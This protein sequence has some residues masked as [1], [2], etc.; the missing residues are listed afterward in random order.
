MTPTPTVSIGMPVYNA[1]RYL[2]RALD[3]LLAQDFRDFEL[4][5]S[6]NGSTDDTEA[7]CRVYAGRDAR[8]RFIR[9]RENRG[10]LWNFAHVL[11]QAQG[12]FFLWA[13]HDDVYAP[14]FISKCLARLR[15]CPSAI[16]CCSEIVFLDEAGRVKPGWTYVNLDTL[17]MSSVDR[18]LELFR[19]VGWFATYSLFRKETLRKALPFPEAYGSD[20]ISLLDLLLLG[21]ITKVPE[22]LFMLMVADQGKSAQQYSE[23]M[24]GTPTSEA[25]A[26]PYTGL[27]RDL[28]VRA[29]R[30]P[31]TSIE[32]ER[33]R[34]E[35]IRILSSE[36]QDWR[37]RI[38][39]ELGPEGREAQ[40]EGEFAR[41]LGK[42]MAEA[43]GDPAPEE[44]SGGGS[45]I[46]PRALVFFPHNPWPAR[47]GAHSRCLTM[48]KA[49]RGLGY[50][51]TLCGSSQFTD[52]P[53]GLE[54]RSHLEQEFE[55]EVHVHEPDAADLA[56]SQSRE[57]ASGTLGLERFCPPGLVRLF[58]ELQSKL[59]AE[60]VLVNY[61]FWGALAEGAPF[62]RAVTVIDSH[63][64]LAP[65]SR[66]NQA[67]K[68]W[69]PGGPLAPSDPSV[70]WL[71]DDCGGSLQCRIEVQDEEEFRIYDRFDLT[72]AISEAEAGILESHCKRTRVA[73]VRMC[74]EE[75][76]TANRYGGRPVFL[77]SDNLSNQQGYLYFVSRVLPLIREQIPGFEIGVAGALCRRIQPTPG[78]VPLGYVEDLA[79]LYSDA[80]FAICPLLGGTGQQ[81]K[82]T[83]AMAYGV[84]VVVHQAVAGSS[85]VVSEVNGFIAGTPETFAA[86]CI[87]LT[88]DDELRRRLGAEA[89][90]AMQQRGSIAFL[91][92]Q[93]N[94]ALEAARTAF[95]NRPQPR[96]TLYVRTD[97]IGDAILSNS[98]LPH[99]RAQWPEEHITV[100]CQERVAE[101]YRACP[102]VD[103]VLSFDRS[104]ALADEAYR[105]ALSTRIQNVGADRT[106]CPVFS[107]EVLTDLLVGVSQAPVRIGMVGDLSNQSADEMA[108]TDAIY[109]HLIPSRE[110]ATSELDRHQDFLSGLGIEADGLVPTVWTTDGD[111]RFAEAHFQRE[112][113]TGSRVLA[114]FPG[115]QYDARV[116]GGYR[117]ILEQLAGEGWRLL[118][119]GSQSEAGLCAGMLRGLNGSAN[120]CGQLSLGQV[121]A[122]LRRC[123]LGLGAESGLAHL[124]CAVGLPNAI[125]LGG[126]HF[127][128]FCPSSPKTVAAVLPLDCYFCNWQ[129]RYSRPHCVKDLAAGVVARAVELAQQPSDRPRLVAQ[130]GSFT[131]RDDHPA[132]IDLA[133]F[134]NLEDVGYCTV[135]VEHSFR[136]SEDAT[137]CGS[138]DPRPLRTTV[139]CAVW[140]QDP[141]RLDLLRGH[142]ACLD[143]L[144]DAVDRIYVFDGG[145]RAPE[146][147]KGK[148]V[149]SREPLTIYEAWNLALP[150]VRTPYVMNL[151]LDDRLCSDGVARLEAALDQGADLACGDWRI[152][153]TRTETDAFEPSFQANE[154]PVFRSWP[155]PTGEAARLGSSGE[156]WTL[157]PACLW[158]TALHKEFPRFP[159]KFA[160]GVLIRTIGDGVW[161]RL[162]DQFGKRI[163]RLPWVIGHY[164]SNPGEQ[165]EFRN[166]PAIEEEKLTRTGIEF[167]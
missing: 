115:A 113:L 3:A 65:N 78:V 138:P 57:P 111:E 44:A 150:L 7:I 25:N 61:A 125:V 135:P 119:F 49:I 5:V 62:R 27:L 66:W 37:G 167:F 117:P 110:G 80:S 64:L 157:G 67:L 56:W 24:R 95:R 152:T 103:D 15:A 23:A 77:A 52:Q 114:F 68:S 81:V 112:G 42:L 86:C 101:L 85:P 41:F 50:D 28:W 60:V 139:L 54:S 48:L 18:I 88:K 154:L 47:T 162:L 118:A 2:R 142:Q 160:D 10:S 35:I 59:Q 20:V 71:A 12:E 17:G 96:R 70:P 29:F 76:L 137:A 108:K 31:L 79:G 106:L 102:L 158:K 11:E 141:N 166:P 145:D 151:N 122:L 163:V 46:A 99:L 124:C 13:A 121:A 9:H 94:Q 146:W 147:L 16:G 73:L 69:I 33:L 144:V 58:A 149:T 43:V 105:E 155:P 91:S 130:S 161:W 156:A 19:R 159:W 87:Q 126:G 21:D 143:T 84:P 51:I 104:R 83:E 89:R 53:W 90:R 39:A 26:S 40:T 132:L 34:S 75:P 36:N 22:P 120:L 38:L 98:I 116:Y 1:E 164:H 72:I 63:D 123:T 109:T 74:H 107:R 131:D 127:G 55:V 6:D 148:V 14:T 153:F 134:L 92:E 133:P 129:C 128:R 45:K 100:L 32:K 30:S 140:H 136:A 165:A 82:V 97:S 93:L 4:I 8:I